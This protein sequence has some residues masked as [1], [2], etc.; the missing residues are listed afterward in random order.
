MIKEHQTVGAVHTCNLVKDKEEK[1]RENKNSK[2]ICRDGENP[3][4][5]V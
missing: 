3:L 4:N 2:L 5:T 1:Y